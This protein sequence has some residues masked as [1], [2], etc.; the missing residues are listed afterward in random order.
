MLCVGIYRY[1]IVDNA[2][3]SN[4]FFF[5]LYTPAGTHIKKPP[6]FREQS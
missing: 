1:C 5:K 3:P 6:T 2:L 4:L